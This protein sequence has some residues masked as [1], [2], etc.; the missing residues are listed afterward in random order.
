LPKDANVAVFLSN[1]GFPTTKIGKYDASTDCYHKNVKDVFESAKKAILQEVKWNGEFTVMQVFGQ[2]L[3]EKYNPG[4]VM[5]SPDRALDEV[6]SQG[7]THVVDIP[8]EFPG[9]SV[10]ILVK[11]R[12]AYGLVDLPNWNEN[13]ETRLKYKNLDVKITSANFYPEHWIESY[14]HRTVDA[15]ERVMTGKRISESRH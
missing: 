9:D 14:R 2:F 7:F 8:Y 5:M 11:L 6:S 13:Y 4:Q 10:D 12:Q 15:I 3:G 1:H